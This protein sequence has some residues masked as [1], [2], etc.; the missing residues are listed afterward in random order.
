MSLIDVYEGYLEKTDN[1]TFGEELINVYKKYSNKV[2]GIEDLLKLYNIKSNIVKMYSDNKY[3][4]DEDKFFDG[5]LSNIKQASLDKIK[6]APQNKLLGFVYNEEDLKLV[7][8]TYNL[9]LTGDYTSSSPFTPPIIT[10]HIMKDIYIGVRELSFIDVI[11]DL[12]SNNTLSELEYFVKSVN[13]DFEALVYNIFNIFPKATSEQ[14][15][16]WKDSNIIDEYSK[17]D[18]KLRNGKFIFSWK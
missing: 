11:E 7:K 2:I 8:V 4:T 17:L 18:V 6:T 3:R 12:T 5:G 13:I 16:S 10:E 14:I 15:E 1:R 9:M